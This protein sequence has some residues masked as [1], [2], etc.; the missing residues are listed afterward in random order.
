VALVYL[1]INNNNFGMTGTETAMG[2][3][4]DK[5][6]H[7]GEGR[8]GAWKDVGIRVMASNVSMA[9]EP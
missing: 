2:N 6:V 1:G 9:K 8:M 7:T 3:R 5:Y 4:Y